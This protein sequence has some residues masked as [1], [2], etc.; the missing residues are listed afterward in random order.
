MQ[1]VSEYED[2]I[3][4]GL[5]E[6]EC[7]PKKKL[8]YNDAIPQLVTEQ[9]RAELIDWLISIHHKLIGPREETL[10]IAVNIIDRILM[11]NI[12]QQ[13]SLHTLAITAFLIATK[14]E[15]IIQPTLHRLC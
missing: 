6:E 3:I 13:S 12:T 10:H 15:D 9:D 11:R 4:Q 5:F 8:E 1:Y 7:H 2:K 14:F